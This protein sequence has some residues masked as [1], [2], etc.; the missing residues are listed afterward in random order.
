VAGVQVNRGGDDGLRRA[1]V[2]L[3][4]TEITSWG[5]LY[6]ALPVAAGDITATEGWSHGQVFTAFSVGLLLSAVAGAGVGRLLDRFGP[7]PVMTVGSLVGVAGLLLVASAQS[8]PTFFAA[9]LV[10][11][12]AQ[13]AALYPPAF[14]AIT[15]WYGDARTW[16]LTV[17]TLVAGL[18]STVF[19]PLTDALVE[20]LGWR[21]AYLVLTGVYALVTVPLHALFLTPPWPGHAHAG[22]PRVR[23]RAIRSVVRSRRFVSLQA[24]LT[25]TGLG[26]YAVTLN[27]IPLLTSRGFG[28]AA[29]ATV[30]GLVGAGQV[31]GRLAFAGLP[32]GHAPHVRTVTI[33]VA[34]AGS[35]A[36]LALL[37]GPALVLV[38][39]A[40]LAGAVRGAF[41]L[42]QATAVAD[43]W[44]TRHFGAL[45]GSFTVP[46][47]AAIALSPAA[48]AL[49]SDV[50][51]SHTAATA[52]FAALAA[53]GVLVGRRA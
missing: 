36:L 3:C 28:H 9:W 29:A 50:L 40:V 24:S 46:I 41:T 26:L 42:L 44:G 33:G 32:V 47:T 45:N 37:P 53:V 52:G 27:L 8:L 51:G 11:G 30:F 43:R 35:L 16:P 10:T 12:L 38:A 14:I 34:A 15:R 22:G 17:L 19:A 48:G 49:A 25:L 1:L 6:Y 7:R 23:R 18:A 13:S 4:V 21:S 2:A 39:A 5:V 31:L 20:A